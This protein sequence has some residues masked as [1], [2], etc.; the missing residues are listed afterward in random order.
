MAGCTI[1]GNTLVAECGRFETSAGYMTD[2][3]ITAGG[4]VIGFINFTGR[5]GTV[6]T[7]I[8][9]RILHLRAVVIDKTTDESRSVMA[10]GTITG[11]GNVTRKRI[12]A[13]N[14]RKI[15]VV[16]GVTAHA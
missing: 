5:I 14:A 16:A 6:V 2:I 7:G 9:T 15:A 12:L 1:T 13:W 3:A 11:G 10:H 8:T 4:Y